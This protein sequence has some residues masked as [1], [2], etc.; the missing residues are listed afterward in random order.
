M[1]HKLEPAPAAACDSLRQS[2]THQTLN[3]LTARGKLWSHHVIALPSQAARHQRKRGLAAGQPIQQ[4]HTVLRQ[5]PVGQQQAKRKEER[6]EHDLE[7]GA[8]ARLLKSRFNKK[9][10]D[11]RGPFQKNQVVNDRLIYIMPPMPPMPP[12]SGMPPP[13]APAFSG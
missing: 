1:G 3:R 10:H 2:F 6:F 11:K 9:A 5:G 13:A 7:I 4:D 12:I 8:R